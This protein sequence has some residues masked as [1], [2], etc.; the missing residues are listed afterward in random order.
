MSRD[1]TSWNFH[2]GLRLSLV[3]L[4]LTGYFSSTRGG[5][6]DFAQSAHR[7]DSLQQ[8]LWEVDLENCTVQASNTIATPKK[9]LAGF[10]R[11]DLILRVEAILST[12]TRSASP[13]ALHFPQHCLAQCT[14]IHQTPPPALSTRGM[15]HRRPR[16]DSKKT[17]GEL[18]QTNTLFLI[19]LDRVNRSARN[20]E[21]GENDEVW[22]WRPWS[23]LIFP[24]PSAPAVSNPFGLMVVNEDLKAI[25]GKTILLCAR[26]FVR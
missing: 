22:V 8:R 9:E 14:I 5:L 21:V 24:N 18:D 12:T 7:T 1:P 2:H 19:C 17:K 25:A 3:H 10:S 15:M 13:H 4:I 16:N 23:R 6:A 26:V 20:L 11:P